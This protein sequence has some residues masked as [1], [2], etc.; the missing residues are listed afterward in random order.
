MT[1]GA[2]GRLSHIEIPRPP[3]PRWATSHGIIMCALTGWN[4]TGSAL[5]RQRCARYGHRAWYIPVRASP[6]SASWTA[7][8]QTGSRSTL[9]GRVVVRDIDEECGK[10]LPD[11]LPTVGVPTNVIWRLRSTGLARKT[12]RRSR[13]STSTYGRGSSDWSAGRSVSP[14]RNRCTIW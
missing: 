6:C 7:S 2:A 5:Y 13:A 11:V 1:A 3:S 10:A 4:G 9:A 14:R 8:D 12:R